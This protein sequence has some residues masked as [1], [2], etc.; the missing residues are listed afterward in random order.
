MLSVVIP[1]YNEQGN[2]PQLREELDAAL[3]PYEYEVIWVED[4][5]TDGTSETIDEYAAVDDRHR[6]VHLKRSY[7]QSVA[8]AA[9][10]DHAQGETIV[11]M[12]GDLQNHPEDIPQLVEKLEEGYD[13]V[14]GWRRDRDDPWHK[15][16]PSAIQTRLA[17]FTGP[18]INDYGCTLSAYRASALEDVE[19]YGERHR[20]IPAQLHNLGYEVAE[21]EV[22]HRPRVNGDS[23]Y[24]VSRLLRGFVD[25]VYHVFWVRYSTRPMQLLGSAGIISMVLGVLLGVVSVGQRYLAGVPLEPRTP[26]LILLSLLVVLGIQLLIF[27]ALMEFLTTMH[28]ANKRPYRIDYTR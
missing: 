5:S 8:L 11:T 24:G 1:V 16:I 4:E 9:G 14:K 28:Y 13:C 18:D 3:Q 21:L 22:T 12:D 10:I 26:R 25:L 17:K 20:Y 2:L 27:G 15:T 19:L 23:R 7:G 6:V